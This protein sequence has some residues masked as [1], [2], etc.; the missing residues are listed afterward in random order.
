[1]GVHLTFVRSV[2]LDEWTQRQIDAMRLG[3]NGSARAYFRKHGMTDLYGGKTEKKYK[4]KAAQA[5]KAELAKLV[6]AEAAKRGEAVQAASDDKPSS[7]LAN[8]DL[9]DQKQSESEAKAK[10]AAAR[11]AAGKPT[12]GVLTPKAKLAASMPGAGKLSVPAGGMLRKPTSSKG[13]GARLLKKKPT[14][15]TSKLRVNKL[16]INLPSSTATNDDFEDIESTQNAIAEA[17][18]KALEEKLAKEKEAEE[19]KEKEANGPAEPPA[20]IP[21]PVPKEEPTPKPLQSSMETNMAKLKAMNGDFF[22]QL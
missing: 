4:S 14:A 9:A 18:K 22:S 19:A 7:L 8:L 21:P 17:E 11:A 16:A 12:T 2:D 13:V 15:T 20:P 3:G 5:Y 1:M 10:L 6:D